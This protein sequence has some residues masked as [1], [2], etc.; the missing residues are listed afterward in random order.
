MNEKENIS[1]TEV[2]TQL[3]IVTPQYWM[4]VFRMDEFRRNFAPKTS[5]SL[6]FSQENT[7]FYKR[8]VASAK[9]G[10]LWRR[11]DN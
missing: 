5:I 8:R 9:F 7:Q 10:Y 2:G 1:T 4:P 6:S 3:N 11:A